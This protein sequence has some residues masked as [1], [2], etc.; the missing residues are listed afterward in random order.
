MFKNVKKFKK[1]LSVLSFVGIL[2]FSVQPDATHAY[3]TFNDHTLTGGVGDWGN[4]TQYYYISDLAQPYSSTIQNAMSSWVNTG[5]TLSTPI[6]FR[7]TSNKP[8]SVMDIYASSFYPATLNTI[9]QT[10]FFR[11]GSGINPSS[12]NWSW[13]KIE[14]NDLVYNNQSSFNQRG[15]VAHEMGHAMGLDH[16]SNSG[17]IMTQLGSGRAVNVPDYNSLQGINYLY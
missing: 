16:T 8:S 12:Q 7:Q 1:Q 14:I 3:S 2:A 13:A 9:G 11:S 5:N 10:T 6:S 4:S 15:T 17:S